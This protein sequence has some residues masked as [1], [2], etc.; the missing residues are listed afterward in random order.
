M[1]KARG[2]TPLSLITHITILVLWV[3]FYLLPHTEP[4]PVPYEGLTWEEEH[5]EW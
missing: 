3:F 2:Y 5:A 4:E 1:I